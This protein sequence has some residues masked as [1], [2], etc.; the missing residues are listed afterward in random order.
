MTRPNSLRI[1]LIEDRTVTAIN[2]E[3]LLEDQGHR[4]TGFAATPLQAERVLRHAAS[5]LDLVILEAVLVGL[6]S[7]GLAKRLKSMGLPVVVT[8]GLP[9]EDLVAL[10]RV[11]PLERPA[12]LATWVPAGNWICWPTSMA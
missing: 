1:M 4:V 10:G 5:E 12:A 2:L 6:P 3:C 7:D 8:S 9:Q 11:G